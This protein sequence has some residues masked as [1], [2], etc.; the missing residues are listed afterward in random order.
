MYKYKC[1]EG[2]VPIIMFSVECKFKFNA[3]HTVVLDG[4]NLFNDLYLNFI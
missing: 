1:L 3:F 2:V 4:I